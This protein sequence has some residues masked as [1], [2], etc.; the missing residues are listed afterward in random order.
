M[1][2]IY[3][4]YSVVYGS[5]SGVSYS[6]PPSSVDPSMIDSDSQ[7]SFWVEY[8]QEII[9]S[10]LMNKSEIDQYLEHGCETRAPNFDILDWWKIN[11][12]KYPILARVA[13]DVMVILVST[14]SS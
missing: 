3:G 13:R 12:V 5:S 10:N 9:E 11:E 14:V 2:D 6:E 1:T 4:E 8:E 7:Q